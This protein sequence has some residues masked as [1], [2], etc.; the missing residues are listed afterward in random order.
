MTGR[1]R[2]SW[3]APLLVVLALGQVVSPVLV[4]LSGSDFFTSDRAGEP[5]IVP[6]GYTFAIWGLVEV[7][8]VSY[9]VWA[10]ATRSNGPLL[11]DRIAA[12]LAVVFA[13]FSLW[14][15][16]VVFEPTW[17]P[18]VIFLLMFAALL[19][20]LSV[21]RAARGEIAGWSPLGRGLLWGML[22]VYTGWTSIAVWVNLTTSLAGS[23]VPVTGTAA[24]LGQLAVLAGATATA[25]A[26][27][28]WTRALL[29]Y[30]AA[31]AWAF[32]GAAIGASAAGEGLLAVTAVIGLVVVTAVTV[33]RRR[34]PGAPSVRRD[35]AAA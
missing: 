14:L 6:A 30:A 20:T 8:A 17:T 32:V 22:G 28:W 1:A 34:S 25:C 2:R 16:A 35:L 4:G 31:T 33:V 26:I 3:S 15:L 19:R 21:A 29:P 11:R 27:V 23:G 7:L 12:P 10:L 13:G 24:V 18:L 5:P 9:A